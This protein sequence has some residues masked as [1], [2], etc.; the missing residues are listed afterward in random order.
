MHKADVFLTNASAFLFY[1]MEVKRL[2][3][4]KTL[5]TLET[6]QE[7]L[8]LVTNDDG[9]QSKGIAALCEVAREFGQVI[10]VA[11]SEGQSGMSHAITVKTPLRLHHMKPDGV[12]RY[13][14]NGT[15]VDC[16]KIA[17]NQI[18]K[19]K[20]TLILSGINHG[21][22]T[23]EAVFYSGTMA[24]TI[25]GCIYGVPSIGFSLT[26]YSHNANFDAAKVFVRKIVAEALAGGISY[27][28]CWN[29]NI[30]AVSLDKIQGIKICRQN[31]GYWKEEFEKRTDPNGHDY[32]WLTGVYH[33]TEPE[34]TDTDE[35][36]IQNN[37]VTIV[38]VHCDLTS[39]K[40]I[41]NLQ[42]RFS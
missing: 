30:P 29:V 20:P 13:A 35:W 17:F 22:N 19:Q 32:F 6:K 14:C 10:M 1:S 4:Q 5:N 33:N 36:A 2:Y 41:E 9:F 34:S 16:V 25:E 42:N 21:S 24:A 31:R 39:Y 27:D 38:P 26:D 23:A 18:L 37:Y 7:P 11:P 12:E 3:L 8:I 15:P 40:S 28:T